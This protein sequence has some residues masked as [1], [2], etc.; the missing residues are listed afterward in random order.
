MKF[1]P[2]TPTVSTSADDDEAANL[3]GLR[4]TKNGLSSTANPAPSDVFTGFGDLPTACGCSAGRTE[5][6][7]YDKRCSNSCIM[8]ILAE[9]CILTEKISFLICMPS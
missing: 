1:A 4:G 8:S 9:N 3:F 2:V 7:Y 5:T 6:G